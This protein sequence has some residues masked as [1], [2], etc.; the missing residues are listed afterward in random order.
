MFFTF[1]DGSL[2]YDCPS[3]GQLC[4]RG[5]GLGLGK[6]ELVQFARLEPRLALLLKASDPDITQMI[7]PIDGCWMLQK[8]GWCS[9]ETTLGRAHK[10]LTCKLFPFNRSFFVG[11]TRFVDFN[12]LLCPLQDA[13]AARDGQSWKQVGDEIEENHEAWLLNERHPA[14]PASEPFDWIGMEERVRDAIELYLDQPDYA[15]FAAYQEEEVMALSRGQPP[16]RPQDSHERTER[17]RALLGQWREL[18]GVAADPRVPAAA[19]AA[20][21]QAALLSSTWRV[22][23]LLNQPTRVK[24]EYTRLIQRIPR[25]LLASAFLVE[26]GHLGRR[27]GQGL[28][29]ATETFT[30]AI[31]LISLLARFGRP[32]R[33]VEPLEQGRVPEPV[34]PALGA[35]TDALRDN[36]GTLGE[37]LMGA[38]TPF[39][40]HLRGLA[41][42][43]LAF[44]EAKLRYE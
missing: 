26:L 2:K 18:L 23:L 42:S 34:R 35:I 39:E 21:R 4:C 14:P 36:Q 41:L 9:I 25:Q 28:R 15:G 10:P 22:Q 3:C 33:L 6:Q 1:L 8:D 17:L 40:P 11:E 30:D 12:S 44:G 37:A 19:R 27:Q 16:P 32:A 24:V 5:K 31:A 20:A 29:T 43:A 7:E 13:S 38:L